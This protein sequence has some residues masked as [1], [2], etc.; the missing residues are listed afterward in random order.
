MI[1][2]LVSE[3]KM[4]M[5]MSMSMSMTMSEHVR[6][7]SVYCWQLSSFKYPER[8]ED[9]QSTSY[10][11]RSIKMIYRNLSWQYYFCP[12]GCHFIFFVKKWHKKTEVLH[13]LSKYFLKDLLLIEKLNYEWLLIFNRKIIIIIIVLLYFNDNHHFIKYFDF[14]KINSLIVLIIFLFC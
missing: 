10:F 11:A 12:E 1:A 7:L 13:L 3:L 14:Y 2:N 8:M 5:S 4:K 6:Q 9:E